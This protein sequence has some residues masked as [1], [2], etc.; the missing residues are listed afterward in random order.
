[1]P[2]YNVIAPYHD[3]AGV[4]EWEGEAEDY[5]DAMRQTQDQAREDNGLD[6][7]S[8]DMLSGEQ[9]SVM[10][11]SA[12]YELKGKICVLLRE[13]A[14]KLDRTRHPDIADPA[15][16]RADY[17]RELASQLEAAGAH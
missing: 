17:M 11:V 12:R 14:D 9:A 6:D 13:E 10:D 1:M 7:E 4:Y 2:I 8:D 3:D 15:S 5:D 16:I